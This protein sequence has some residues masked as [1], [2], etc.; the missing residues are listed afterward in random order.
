MSGHVDL[1]QSELVVV[2]VVQNVHQVGVERV[3]LLELGKLVENERETIMVVLLGVF[4]L[5][6]IE[7]ADTADAVLLVD[8][9]GR[10]ALGLGQDHID[11][12]LF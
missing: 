12:V 10:L 8:D 11:E 3:H 1:A 4:D 9:S 7:L 2:L 6:G 5:S